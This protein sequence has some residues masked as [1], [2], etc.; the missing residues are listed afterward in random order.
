MSLNRIA[1]TNGKG[2]GVADDFIFPKEKANGNQYLELV[3]DGEG[4]S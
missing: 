1:E 2:K 3:A 4:M